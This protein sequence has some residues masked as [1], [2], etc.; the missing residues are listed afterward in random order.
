MDAHWGRRTV[1]RR[2]LHGACIV[3]QGPSPAPAVNR[4]RL[5]RHRP[6]IPFLIEPVPRPLARLRGPLICRS[7]GPGV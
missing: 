1:L 5:W 7:S 2:E 4:G 3:L 6:L